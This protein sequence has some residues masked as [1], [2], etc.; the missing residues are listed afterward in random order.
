MYICNNISL[1]SVYNGKYFKQNLLKTTKHTFLITLFRNSCR[2]WDNVKQDRRA[3]QATNYNTVHALCMLDNYSFRHAVT[4]CTTYCFSK[5]ITV[6]RTHLNIT[7]YLHWLSGSLN[8][9]PSSW[10]TVSKYR[11]NL[12]ATYASVWI[13]WSYGKLLRFC[14]FRSSQNCSLHGFSVKYQDNNCTYLRIM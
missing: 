13:K 2:L 12:A 14:H 9:E 1:N 3:R 8:Y 10:Y 4:I 7:L 6:T 11:V 5:A